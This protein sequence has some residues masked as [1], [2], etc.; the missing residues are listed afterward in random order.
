MRLKCDSSPSRRLEFP[1]LADTTG[2]RPQSHRREIKHLAITGQ[3][4]SQVL[5]PQPGRVISSGLPDLGHYRAKPFWLPG[6]LLKQQKQLNEV[7]V[8]PSFLLG[9]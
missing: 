6:L 7:R 1:S 5:Q 3:V 4:T 2:I 8:I 9:Y